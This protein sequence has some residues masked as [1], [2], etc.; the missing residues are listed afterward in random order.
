[1]SE[2]KVMAE[3]FMLWNITAQCFV[4]E[5]TVYYAA[6]TIAICSVSSKLASYNFGHAWNMDKS[7]NL[8]ILE[9]KIC[10]DKHN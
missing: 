1:M 9:E 5:A 8:L 4:G 6:A 7:P 3:I 2:V 10:K